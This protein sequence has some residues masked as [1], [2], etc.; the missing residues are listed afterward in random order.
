MQSIWI[1]NGRLIDPATGRDEIADLYIEGGSIAN[2]PKTQPA[3][4]RVIDAR[5]LVVVP[6]FIDLHVHLREPGNEAAETVLTGCR[7]AARGGF[8]TIVAM[9]NTKPPLDTPD[10]IRA[11]ARRAEAA[12]SIRVL[13]APCI[14]R[15]RAGAEV[16]DLEKLATAGA[17]AFTDDGSTVPDPAVMAAAMRRAARLNLPIMDHALDPVL[18]GQGVMREGT[19]SRR[20]GLPGIPASAEYTIVERNIRLA[21][22]TGCATHIQHVSAAESVQLIR[23]ARRRGMRVSAEVTPH[24]LAL[25]DDDVR[26][27]DPGRFKMSPPLGSAADLQALR[28]AIADGTIEAFA[29]DHAPHTAETK[30]RGFAGAPFGVIG[31]ETAVGA[32]Y[33]TMVR[34]HRM[35]LAAWVERWTTGP[36]RILG[37]PA[38]TLAPGASADVTLLDLEHEWSVQ[39]DTFT[40]KSRNTPFAGWLLNGRAVVTVCNGTI[41]WEAPQ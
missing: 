32:T 18:A 38:P 19:R 29:T 40:S 34:H 22:E 33:T 41:V 4:V 2:A 17:A 11:L 9:P 14:T 25:A 30:A 1:K 39:P 12:Q 3:G 31:L 24:H 27:D 37:R 7:A 15:Q 35:P 26:G 21:G 5:G 6:G 36:A 20:L 13:A 8:T 16:A 23:D 28:E 10:E